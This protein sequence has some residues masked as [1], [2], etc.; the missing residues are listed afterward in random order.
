MARVSL[1]NLSCPAISLVSSC[2]RVIRMGLLSCK[3]DLPLPAPGKDVVELTIGGINHFRGLLSGVA[4]KE[5]ALVSISRC[6]REAL[7]EVIEVDVPQ[8]WAQD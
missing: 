1:P 8:E 2:E 6:H 3:L 5:C 4:V 7:Q